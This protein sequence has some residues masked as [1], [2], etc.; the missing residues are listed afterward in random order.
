[1]EHQAASLGDAGVMRLY[2]EDGPSS[3]C[4]DEDEEDGER[5]GHRHRVESRLGLQRLLKVFGYSLFR[6]FGIFVF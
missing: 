3:G 4:S 1:V 6:Y 5:A 2:L